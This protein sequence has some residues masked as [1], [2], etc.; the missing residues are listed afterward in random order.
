MQRTANSSKKITSNA[1]PARDASKFVLIRTLIRRHSI[2]NF[3]SRLLE[4][5]IVSNAKGYKWNVYA[6][7]AYPRLRINVK[8]VSVKVKTCTQSLRVQLHCIIRV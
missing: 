4:F 3:Q 5:R 8:H 7:L 2:R 6:H 1:F